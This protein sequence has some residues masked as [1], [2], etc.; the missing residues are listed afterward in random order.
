VHSAGP[1]RDASVT[2]SVQ[3]LKPL[4]TWPSRNV[5]PQSIWHLGASWLLRTG[6]GLAGSQL[7]AIVR[8]AAKRLAW[9]TGRRRRSTR[10]GG[11]RP[12]TPAGRRSYRHRT[13][14]LHR[15]RVSRAPGAAP[16][17]A[18]RRTRLAGRCAGGRSCRR[19]A[20]CRRLERSARPDAGVA[21][22]AGFA[23]LEVRLQRK[24]QLRPAG[25]PGPRL[26]VTGAARARRR[27]RLAAEELLAG[28]GGGR[29]AERRHVRE[30]RAANAGVPAGPSQEAA[31]GRIE[32]ASS[33]RW[34]RAW[35]VTA[36][37]S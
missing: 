24:R 29:G 18:I 22:I 36:R 7:T 15:L 28:V 3:R 10:R 35:V 32:R 23:G 19:S 20:R 27:L 31:A 14:V 8:S 21:R 26:T 1:A 37:T 16:A 9:R 11:Q 5:M 17:T 34:G 33:R 30:H 25:A 4:S 12:R 13:A 6:P 2:D